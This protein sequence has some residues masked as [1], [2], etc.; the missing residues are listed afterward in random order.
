MSDFNLMNF[1]IDKE[2]RKTIKHEEIMDPGSM[3]DYNGGVASDD[4]FNFDSFLKMD[5]DPVVDFT[6]LDAAT[7]PTSEFGF[8]PTLSSTSVPEGS[9]YSD[10]GVSCTL[11]PPHHGMCDED[12]LS[13][14]TGLPTASGAGS[15]ETTNQSVDDLDMTSDCSTMD[16]SIVID[17]TQPDDHQAQTVLT[18]PTPPAAQLHQPPTKKVNSVTK[19]NCNKLGGSVKTKHRVLQNSSLNN[20]TLQNSPSIL[21]PVNLPGLKT[22]KVVNA[23]GKPLTSETLGEISS[24][25]GLGG[26]TLKLL[27]AGARGNS[28]G[29]PATSLSLSTTSTDDEDDDDDDED[30]CSRMIE[31][32]TSSSASQADDPNNIYPKLVLTYE[33]RRLMEKEGVRLP[34][35]YPLTKL[36]ERELKRIRRKIRNK[37]SAQDSRKRKKEYVD[38][39]EERVKKCTAENVNLLKRIKLLESRNH[40]LCSQ[41]RKIQTLLTNK[42]KLK[43]RLNGGASNNSS[44]PTGATP[45]G[46]STGAAHLLNNNQVQ[47]STCL[48]VLCLS[49]ALI[50]APNLQNGGSISADSMGDALNELS[51]PS[52]LEKNVQHAS[53]GRSRSLL[54][55]KYALSGASKP[56]MSAADPKHAELVEEVYA[57]YLAA[58]GVPAHPP[59]PDEKAKYRAREPQGTVGLQGLLAEMSELLNFKSSGGQKRED[60]GNEVE[61]IKEEIEIKEEPMEPEYEVCDVESEYEA[62]ECGAGAAGSNG[63][64]AAA[65]EEILYNEHNYG[66]PMT[67]Q[68]RANPF[69]DDDP[70]IIDR[71]KL[72]LHEPFDSLESL[73]HLEPLKKLASLDSLEPLIS[74][75]AATA[76]ESLQQQVPRILDSPVDEFAPKYGGVGAGVGVVSSSSGDSGFERERKYNGS[77]RNNRYVA[78]EESYIE[79]E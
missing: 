26:S 32:V 60:S 48:M 68:K 39:L 46:A 5:E 25:T 58:G 77:M 47:S 79:V 3:W 54:F 28:L 35:H 69:G 13:G 18:M 67:A 76:K 4:L 37:I 41:L 21:I 24:K 34:S 57:K 36:E 30:S 9:V 7:D 44:G 14:K 64:A 50:L 15:P 78:D 56:L 66:K 75:L 31:E 43:S 71:K 11:S 22:I 23:S 2:D 55:T 53:S 12:M 65:A 49:L 40:T 19:S 6:F 17:V 62:R 38:G 10:S 73:K 61:E 63:K 51:L 27:S 33:E 29:S 59:A 70:F 52:T 20:Q 72:A 74:L 45:N 42:S 8:D 1:L 16:T